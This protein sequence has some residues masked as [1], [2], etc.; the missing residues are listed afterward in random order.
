MIHIPIVVMQV[1]RVRNE[2]V[3]LFDEMVKMSRT[4]PTMSAVS[5]E[6]LA[7]LSLH[8][9]HNDYSCTKMNHVVPM[10]L[11]KPSRNHACSFDSYKPF[12][13]QEREK[14]LNE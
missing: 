5:L 8:L 11:S 9:H 1:S 7:P 12:R 4:W 2:L 10:N 3:L 13:A 6:H 14:N